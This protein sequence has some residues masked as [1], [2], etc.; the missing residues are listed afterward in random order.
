[1]APSLKRFEF[2]EM[3]SDQPGRVVA[4][5][6]AG[7]FTER[8]VTQEE[9]NFK[10]LR[11]NGNGHAALLLPGAEFQRSTALSHRVVH[12]AAG[13]YETWSPMTGVSGFSLDPQP[14]GA[15]ISP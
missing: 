15:L 11:F 1:L 3:E 4:P 12:A 2:V 14:L 5:D 13:S 8:N 10:T 9:M 6:S 7:S